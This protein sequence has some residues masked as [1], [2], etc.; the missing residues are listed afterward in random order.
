MPMLDE[1]TLDDMIQREITRVSIMKAGVLYSDVQGKTNLES[2]QAL[3]A[4]VRKWHDDLPPPIQLA[5]VAQADMDH[6]SRMVVHYLHAFH[7][8]TMMLLHRRSISHLTQTSDLSSAEMDGTLPEW[9]ALLEEGATVAKRSARILELLLHEGA[10]V[11]RCW[12]CMWVQPA[13]SER[14]IC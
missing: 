13:R 9:S 1:L 2:T 5:N 7:L 10:V 14:S 11:K 6:D 12:L 3:W 8:S 4:T